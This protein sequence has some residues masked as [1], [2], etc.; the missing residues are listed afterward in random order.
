MAGIETIT[1][2]IL[3]DARSAAEEVKA[4]ACAA[5]QAEAARILD[6]AQLRAQ[7]LEQQDCVEAEERA[8]RIRGVAELEVRKHL[9]S[10]KR[11]LLAQVYAKAEQALASLPD[12]DFCALYHKVCLNMIEHGNEG[13]APAQA[14]AGRLNEAFIAG[15]NEALAQQGKAN[16]LVLAEPRNDI[17]GGCVIVSGGME[18]D[19]STAALIHGVQLATEGEVSRLLFDG[20]EA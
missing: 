4:Q 3:A 18:V 13:I 10:A 7:N 15:L 1:Q 19:L 2:K 16:G 20:T 9:L 6:Q 8:R 5:A 12:G 17:A 14:D 11:D